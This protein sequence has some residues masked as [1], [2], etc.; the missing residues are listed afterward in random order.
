M[1]TN[2]FKRLNEFVMSQGDL[3]FIKT[4]FDGREFNGIFLDMIH[5]DDGYGMYSQC[6][7]IVDSR[8]EVLNDWHKCILISRIEDAL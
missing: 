2:K 6:R 4:F 8:V 7:F 1:L 5:T 3:F